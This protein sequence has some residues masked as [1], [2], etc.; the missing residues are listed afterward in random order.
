MA[1]FAENNLARTIP[2]RFLVRPIYMDTSIHC[3]SD[4]RNISSETE[5]IKIGLQ[6]EIIVLI[7][8]FSRL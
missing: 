1:W 2:G 8:L 4:I 5:L 3:Y 6:S 7:P